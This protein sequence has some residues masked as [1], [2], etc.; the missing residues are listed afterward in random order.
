[1]SGF[2]RGWCPGCGDLDV[3][4]RQPLLKSAAK[5][6]KKSDP[7]PGSQEYLDLTNEDL[8]FICGAHALITAWGRLLLRGEVDGEPSP[9]LVGA[10]CVAGDANWETRSS[11]LKS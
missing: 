8:S 9:C 10:P 7:R 1:M 4:R 3:G 5:G 11:A 2:K 6:Q